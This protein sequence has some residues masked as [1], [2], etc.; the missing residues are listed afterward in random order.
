M[1]RHFDKTQSARGHLTA[2]RQ[3]PY[4][5]PIDDI[6]TT[7]GRHHKPV[8]GILGGV[9]SGKS[10]VAAEFAR[11]GCKVIDA[12]KI[13]HRLLDKKTVRK[14]IIDLFGQAI[15]NTTG[16]I[17][18][19]KL[20]D[21]VFAGKKK[22]MMLNKIIHPLV[23]AKTEQLIKQYNSQSGTKAIVLDMPLLAEVGWHKHCDRLIFVDCKRQKRL[24]RAEKSGLFA[25]NQLKR[26]NFQ[27]SLDKKA[28]ISDNTIDNNSDLSALVR[29][30]AEVFSRITNEEY[31]KVKLR[32]ADGQ[33][34]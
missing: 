5:V 31:Q 25:K 24:K 12:D 6:G 29:Q 28:R 34:R 8:I 16:K 27:I 32:D 22:L 9:C 3:A 13:A 18:R 1:V 33:L 14:K 17:S 26:E 11:L 7:K 15:L 19:R 23:L 4:F 21:V 20:A 2:C 10:T 30:V